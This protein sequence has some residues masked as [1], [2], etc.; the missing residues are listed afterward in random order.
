MYISIDGGGTKTE[1]CIY[2]PDSKKMQHLFFE[3][4][5]INQIGIKCFDERIDQIFSCLPLGEKPNVCLGI[6]GYGESSETDRKIN[7]VIENKLGLTNYF[8]IND[9]VMAHYASLALEDG[10]IVLSGTGAMGMSIKENKMTRA[11]GWGYLL[12]D[13][14]SAFEIGLNALIHVANVFDEIDAPSILSDLICERYSVDFPS[15]LVNYVYESKNYRKDIASISKVVNEAAESGCEQ[16]LKIMEEA[17]L[18]LVKCIKVLKKSDEDIVSYAGSVFKSSIFIELIET[19][20][21]IKFSPPVLEPVLGG[22]LKMICE[23]KSNLDK[24][25][26][27]NELKEIYKYY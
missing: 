17:A 16:S 5:N 20:G 8:M 1:V 12:G 27:V 18:N 2:Y 7:E 6:P 24:E 13:K 22:V 26:C 10:I 11:G 9:V 14:G 4:I 19:K 3:G 23:N 25:K 15:K 21:G